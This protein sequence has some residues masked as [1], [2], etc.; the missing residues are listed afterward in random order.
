MTDMPAANWSL[1][2]EIRNHW[3]RRAATFDDAF[4]HRILPGPEFDAWSAVLR[5]HLGERP[6]R[7][8]ELACGT[9]EITRVLLSLGHDVT[10]MDFCEAMLDRAMAKHAGRAR[11]RF[12]LGDAENTM[13]PDGAYDA[14]VCR[15]LVWTLTDPEAALRDWHRV[16]RPGGRAVVFDGNFVRL[17]ARGRAA[18]LLMDGLARWTGADGHRDPALNAQH[19][20]ILAA[21]PFAGG[22]DFDALAARVRAHGFTVAERGGYGPILRA[23]RA[24]ASGAQDWLRTFLHDRFVLVAGKPGER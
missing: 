24:V 18:R 12:R 3:S 21:L 15:H 20:Q 5:D 11:V 23:Q 10:G 22:L 16:L 1:K 13:E 9:G 19:V 17:P 14:V 6:L 2:E 4:G 8:L 7:V